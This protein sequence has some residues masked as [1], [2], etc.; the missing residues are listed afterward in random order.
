MGLWEG[1]VFDVLALA[2]LDVDR[3]GEEDDIDISLEVE[4]GETL[5]ETGMFP[6]GVVEDGGT[7]RD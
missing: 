6:S 7:S 3:E 1:L 5:G 4:H 2:W